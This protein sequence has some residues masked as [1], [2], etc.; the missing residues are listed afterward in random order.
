MARG[1]RWRGKDMLWRQCM[2]TVI[3]CAAAFVAPAAAQAPAAPSGTIRM[4]LA[5]GRLADVTGA[6]LHFRLVRV[7]LEAGRTS[8]YQAD[9]SVLYV[10][11][12]RLTITS[13]GTRRALDEGGAAYQAKDMSATL[14]AEGTRPAVFLRFVLAPPGRL[15]APLD[16]APATVAELHR[17]ATAIPGLRPGPYEFG[18]TR[19]LVPPGAKPRPMHYRTGAALYYLLSGDG[20]L[21][22][23]N[24]ASEMHGAGH[25]QFEPQ[26]FIHTWSNVGATPLI[27]LQANLGQE[28]VPEIRFLQ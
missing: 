20:E 5:V 4:L 28:G 23:Q 2:H 17:T 25:V 9:D 16:A 1:G 14:M 15:D 3:V 18:M 11:A 13:E 12:G 24:G 6:P 22:I 10:L 21:A 7:T 19:V 8:T 27:L 26:S